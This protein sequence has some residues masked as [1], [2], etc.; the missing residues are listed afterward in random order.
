MPSPPQQHVTKVARVKCD[1]RSAM[2]SLKQLAKCNTGLL[3]K[4]SNHIFV[5]HIETT[6]EA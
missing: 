4:V 1:R 2:A 6:T 3:Q 5:L